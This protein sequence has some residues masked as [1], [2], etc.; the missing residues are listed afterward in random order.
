MDITAI[1]CEDNSI[2]FILCSHVF[3]HVPDDLLAMREL[4]RVLKPGGTAILQVPLDKSLE[5]TLEDPTI[6]TKEL[7]EK[8]YGH[9]DHLRQYG[10][11]YKEKLES[12]GF[13]VK[14]D[15][16]NSK[17]SAADKFKFGLPADEDIYVCSK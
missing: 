14:V 4:Y 3:E 15:D 8:H 16:Y 9:W 7:R 17:F 1:D 12:A 10:L 5:H 13:D 2:D 11:D 6:N